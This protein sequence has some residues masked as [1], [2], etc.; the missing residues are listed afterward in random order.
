[1]TELNVILQTADML[2]ILRFLDV[3]LGHQNLVHT[4]HRGQSLRNVVTSLREF[5]QGIDDAVQNHQ[6]I[7]KGGTRHG[8]I[9]QHLHATEP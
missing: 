6:V 1:M 7:D 3:I 5:L 9:V 2:G 4:L 8:G